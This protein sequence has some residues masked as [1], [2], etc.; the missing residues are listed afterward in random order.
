MDNSRFKFRAWDKNKK[1]MTDVDHLTWGRGDIDHGALSEINEEI[2][3]WF[4]LMQYT[5]LKD[6]NGESIYEGDL[7]KNERG[8]TAR[9]EWNENLVLFDTLFVSDDGSQPNPSIDNS[10]GFKPV[11]WASHV[12]VIGNIYENPE[13]LENDHE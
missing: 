4:E 12:E 9:V 3:K 10:Y 13:L 6:K 11:M 8:R 1:K 2:P 7:I 5:G